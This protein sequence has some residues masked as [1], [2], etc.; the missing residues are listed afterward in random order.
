MEHRQLLGAGLVVVVVTALLVVLVGVPLISTHFRYERGCAPNE[1]RVFY[2]NLNVIDTNVT[3]SFVDDPDLLYQI[4]VEEYSHGASHTPTYEEDE[5]SMSFY[6]N[7]LDSARLEQVD[8]RLG[9]GTFC[10]ILIW[11]SNIN[12]SVVFG[13]RA[14]LDGQTCAFISDGRVRFEFSEDVS[15]SNSSIDVVVNGA[16]D[17][18]VV[19]DLPLGM[20][21]RMNVKPSATIVS[22]SASGWFLVNS[23]VWATSSTDTPLLYIDIGSKHVSFDLST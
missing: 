12:A 13:N 7:G 20:N 16:D 23:T 11:G 15:F 3:V 18:T 21:G 22:Q 4:D 6:I 10:D 8:V 14:K 1:T 19:V 9:T 2:L 5:T 17:A